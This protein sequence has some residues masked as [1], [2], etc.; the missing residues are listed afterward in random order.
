MF[1]FE[2][3]TY[4]AKRHA[5]PYQPMSFSELKSLVLG[6]ACNWISG[7]AAASRLRGRYRRHNGGV[8]HKYECCH[9]H[10][11]ED[12]VELKSDD[13]F[14]IAGLNIGDGILLSAS[15]VILDSRRYLFSPLTS[16]PWCLTNGGVDFT[17]GFSAASDMFTLRFAVGKLRPR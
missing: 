9:S 10:S 7:Q 15:L 2:G 3:K 6:I 8:K 1:D 16:V 5:L 12:G 11:Y 4:M 17:C 14:W 13:I